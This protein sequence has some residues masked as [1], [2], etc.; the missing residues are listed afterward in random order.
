MKEFLSYATGYVEDPN[1]TS[2]CG[3]CPYRYSSFFNFILIIFLNKKN[4]KERY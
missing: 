2:N 1:A 3:Y 4:I